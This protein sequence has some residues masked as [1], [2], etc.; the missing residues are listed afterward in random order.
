MGVY[1]ILWEVD[2]WVI[3]GGIEKINWL[4]VLF[5]V[6]YKDFDIEGCLVLGLVGC[7]VNLKNWWEGS[8]YY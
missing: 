7:L 3:C 6:Y 8:V 1:F 5:Y 2:D 4:E